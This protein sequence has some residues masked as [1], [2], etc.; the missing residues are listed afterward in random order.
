MTT[1]SKQSNEIYAVL[2]ELRSSSKNEVEKG[3]RFERLIREYLRKEPTFADRFEWVKLWGDWDERTDSDTGIDIVAL[4]K[5]TQKVC[6]I[7]C[8]FY[9]EDAML[10]KSDVDS[11]LATVGQARF[12]SHIL[13]HTAGGL[14]NHLIKALD[15]YDP[16]VIVL[17]ADELAKSSGVSWPALSQPPEQLKNQV[18][19][20]SLRPHQEEAVGNVLAAF[21]GTHQ[22]IG[23]LPAGVP[24]DRGK[25]I[26]A[27]GSGKTYT[28]L[29][30][31]E[32]VVGQGGNVLYLVPSISLLSQ[33]LKEWAEQ[34]SMPHNYVGVCSDTTAGMNSEYE[35]VAGLTIPVST[36]PENIANAFCSG[37]AW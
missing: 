23:D 6:A 2:H 35:S 31:A 10:G 8:K 17:D 32:Q 11:F 1:P 27:C 22:G 29:Q 36:K 13:V 7:Q 5:R 3:Q 28:A 20:Y 16:L 21:D 12:G 15:Q 33:S 30:I 37:A 24:A 18:V 14:S 4:D 25:L 26:M 34:R 19:R 9:A